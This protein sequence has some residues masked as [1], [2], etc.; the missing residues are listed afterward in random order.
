MIDEKNETSQAMTNEQYLQE[1][2][3]RINAK[4]E[5]MVKINY[6]GGKKASKT[7]RWTLIAFVVA[8]FVGIEVYFY[9]ENNFW[10]IN[11][12]MAVCMIVCII[13]FYFMTL[14][15]RCFLSRMK[16]ASTAPQYYRAVKRLILTHKLRYLIP[17]AMA[18]VAGDLF[19][20]R[21]SS[22]MS[23][24][25]SIPAG[26]ACIIGTIIGASMRNWH[27]DEDF[28]YDVEEL[29]D[30]IKQESAD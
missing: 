27:L 2:R 12:L 29:S 10:E 22:F 17:L 1:L 19:S 8:L 23:Y 3:Q 7:V 6:T 25:S 16:N 13:G 24:T 28:C 9:K 21:L 11:A 5:E 20:S 18:W 4:A 30:L 14:I 26:I 15:M